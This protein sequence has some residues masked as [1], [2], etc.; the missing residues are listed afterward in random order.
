VENR[1][2]RPDCQ[3][4]RRC[5]RCYTG[6]IE[7]G[8]QRPDPHRRASSRASPAVGDTSR[9][10]KRERPR[11]NG[12]AVTCAPATMDELMERYRERLNELVRDM[13]ADQQRIETALA[14]NLTTPLASASTELVKNGRTSTTVE[15]RST[16]AASR[17]SA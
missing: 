10:S 14:E 11:G 7:Q 15:P 12:A 3:E 1:G 2:V 9:A 5:P 17:R 8:S 4:A 6:Q 13:L 16:A